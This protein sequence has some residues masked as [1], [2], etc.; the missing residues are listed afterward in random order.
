LTRTVHHL[1]KP[2]R[3][4]NVL[5]LEAGRG[6]R[7]GGAAGRDQLDIVR[8]KRLCELDQA[9]LVGDGEKGTGDAAGMVSHEQ[10]PLS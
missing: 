10:D 7:L 9:G 2:V 8:G 6:D 5:H 1:G 3:L 4:G